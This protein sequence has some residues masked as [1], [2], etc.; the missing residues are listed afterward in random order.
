MSFDSNPS[1]SKVTF[2]EY[3]FDYFNLIGGFQPCSNVGKN[4]RLNR[5]YVTTLY[6]RFKDFLVI[7]D[8]FNSSGILTNIIYLLYLNVRRRLIIPAYIGLSI[9]VMLKH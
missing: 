8:G 5:S 6:H 4:F 2:K 9:I 1:P 7:K 3:F